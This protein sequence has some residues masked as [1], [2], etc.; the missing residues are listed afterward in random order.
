MI[1]TNYS[2][3]NK[4]VLWIKVRGASYTKEL[5]TNLLSGYVHH[6]VQ[7]GLTRITILGMVKY[8]ADQYKLICNKWLKVIGA[9]YT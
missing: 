3:T 6:Q 1:K 4:S 2:A 5:N 7:D 9:C 8:V